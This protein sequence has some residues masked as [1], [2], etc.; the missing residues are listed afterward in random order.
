MP[1]TKLGSPPLSDTGLNSSLVVVRSASTE[2]NDAVVQIVDQGPTETI[3][4]DND[5]FRYNE[6]ERQLF[7]GKTI[8]RV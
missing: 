3:A 5:I 4:D 6:T 7:K 2:T 8:A 1:P